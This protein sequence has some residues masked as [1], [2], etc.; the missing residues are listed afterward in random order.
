[1]NY[2]EPSKKNE[3]LLDILRSVHKNP[4]SSQR[5]LAQNLGI[6]LGKLNYLIKSLSDRGLIKIQ[7]F[8]KS[9]N[10]FNYI[11]VLTPAGIK[12]KF[13]LTLKFMKIKIKEY[14]ELK[15]EIKNVG[16]SENKK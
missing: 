10:K 12:R 3:V 14:D 13:N 11:Y 16:S 2:K 1:M 9:K 6:S 7:N 8:S 4:N 5:D 15:D